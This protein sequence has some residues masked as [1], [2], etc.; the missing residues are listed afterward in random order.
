MKLW[1]GYLPNCDQMLVSQFESTNA[2]AIDAAQE[3]DNLRQSIQDLHQKESSLSEGDCETL[4]R[5]RTQV[6]SKVKA[7]EMA[8]S[9]IHMMISK[10]CESKSTETNKESFRD[11]VKASKSTS[12]NAATTSDL[13]GTFENDEIIILKDKS[14]YFQNQFDSD[15][16]WPL[17]MD[18]GLTARSNPFSFTTGTNSVK[19]ASTKT[20][21]TT[22]LNKLSQL[23]GERY[24]LPSVEGQHQRTG[25]VKGTKVR[26]EGM[27]SHRNNPSMDDE[28]HT[29]IYRNQVNAVQRKLMETEA[30][31]E[32][33][34]GDLQRVESD[35]N[36][37]VR[38]LKSS[39]RDRIETLESYPEYLQLTEKR[40][41]DTVQS[42]AH[43]EQLLRDKERE[44]WNLKE[45]QEKSKKETEDYK[46]QLRATLSSKDLMGARFLELEKSNE[47]LRYIMYVY[48]TK[49]IHLACI[50]LKE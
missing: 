5:L 9:Q 25:F 12:G 23:Y 44:V 7:F 28:G 42:K 45:S 21:A 24:D 34:K 43:L 16:E 35:S 48:A 27:E 14:Q 20:S 46:E 22:D 15:Q 38:M 17:G 29:D 4:D 19:T 8:N 18:D 26:F 39:F 41:V 36:F 6:L 13:K 10:K 32:E 37:Q 33:L 1:E 40:L 3:V 47:M 49:Y 31:V 30:E 11:E 50:V 2:L